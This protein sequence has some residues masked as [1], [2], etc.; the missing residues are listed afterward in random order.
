MTTYGSTR[1]EFVIQQGRGDVRRPPAPGWASGSVEKAAG[2]L[3]LDVRTASRWYGRLPAVRIE[4]KR[5]GG[6]GTIGGWSAYLAI[7]VPFPGDAAAG[8]RARLLRFGWTRN[9]N[10]T[11]FLPGP[12]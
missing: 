2:R 8:R 5:G 10:R 6:A 1:R 12:T 3:A 7:R 4:L 11:P 9:A